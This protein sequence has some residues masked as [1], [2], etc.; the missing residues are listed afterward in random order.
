MRI[1]EDSLTVGIKDILSRLENLN[2]GIPDEQRSIIQKIQIR[3]NRIEHHRYDRKD[4]DETIIAESLK[5]IMYFVEFVLELNL[6]A[7]IEP[8]LLHEI[9]GMIFSYNEMDAL[10]D[11]RL[12]QWMK[13]TWPAWDEYET[14]APDEFIGTLDCP[15]CR[16]SYL[17]IEQEAVFCFH[18]NS[19]V[20]A[21]I[22]EDCGVTYLV[23]EGCPWC[24]PSDRIAA[25][26]AMQGV[27]AG[28]TPIVLRV[29]AEPSPASQ[30]DLGSPG[31]L[32]SEKPG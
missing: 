28:K 14:D 24:G 18:C 20:D 3:R 2:L 7:D 5:F 11:N 16:Q 32:A 31:S 25:Y 23:S 26:A 10:A 17:V 1:T 13:A 4:E 8:R 19:S 15:I 27:P 22:C 29:A 30:G 9:Q 21:A 12:K 6:G